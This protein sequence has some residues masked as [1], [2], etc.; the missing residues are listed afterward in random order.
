MCIKILLKEYFVINTP[1]IFFGIC[2]V[3]FFFW[4]FNL[5]EYFHINLI[6]NK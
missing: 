3:Y 1:K 2:I 4:I 5:L 6:N